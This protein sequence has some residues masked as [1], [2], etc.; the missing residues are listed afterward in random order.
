MSVKPLVLNDRY[1]QS[2]VAQLQKPAPGLQIKAI[3]PALSHFLSQLINQ[4]V[5]TFT[6]TILSS[7][8]WIPDSWSTLSLVFRHATLL[9]L[10][11]IHQSHRSYFSNLMRS[12]NSQLGT[13]IKAV[14]SGCLLGDPYLRASALGGLLEGVS[15]ARNNDSD[16]S[17]SSSEVEDELLL[18]L[19][20]AIG[21]IRAYMETEWDHQDKVMFS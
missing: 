4:H 7:A 16:L 11:E 14:T 17:L 18:V 9:K 2:L 5:S 19:A 12:T 8:L 21:G 15:D 3:Q 13:W 6:A 1:Y 10:N 20:E